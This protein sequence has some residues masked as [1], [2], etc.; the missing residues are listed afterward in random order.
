MRRTEPRRETSTRRK[1]LP[2]YADS[3]GEK[4]K[5]PPQL[6]GPIC[7]GHLQL[8]LFRTCH[9]LPIE[10]SL[11]ITWPSLRTFVSSLS[12]RDLATGKECPRAL[13]DTPLLA[14]Y[15]L[16]RAVLLLSEVMETMPLR[17]LVVIYLSIVSAYHKSGL[18]LYSWV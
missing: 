6:W 13:P 18:L 4:A 12:R 1:C 7:Q 11:L 10:L 15:H 8:I 3:K 14:S 17:K 16:S 2:T 5:G 9:G